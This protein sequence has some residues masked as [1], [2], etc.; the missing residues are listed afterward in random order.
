[1]KKEPAIPSL[2]FGTNISHWLSQASLNRSEMGKWFGEDDVR[3]IADW[4]MDHIRVPVD[5][6]LLENEGAEGHINMEGF[7]WIEK[8]IAW[9]DR[10][11][12]NMI[13][14]MHCLPGHK[15]QHEYLAYN[16]I[17]D[18]DSP[19]RLRARK[20]WRFLA[21]K[22]T[23]PYVIFE[24][25]NEPVAREDR[26]WNELAHELHGEIRSKNP[27]Q[28]IMIG[29]NR[30]NHAQSFETLEPVKDP[31]S[32]YTFHLYE[33]FLF[34]HQN[35]EWVPEMRHLNGDSVPY[36]G[37]F[38]HPILQVV[39]SNP[40]HYE[41]MTKP[42]GYDFLEKIIQPILNFQEKFNASCYCG[43]FG[44]ISG[45][46][47]TDRN[48]WYHDICSLFSNHSIGFSNWDYRSDNFGIVSTDDRIDKDTI[49]TMRRAAGV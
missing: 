2:R 3:R 20:L 43:E 38:T 18:T 45:A 30:W 16:Q 21:E 49:E 34:T 27:S 33:P 6:P 7:G 26:M 42:Y 29:S 11:S 1:M 32:I 28:W 35:A 13:L 5:Y 4:G 47:S 23:E 14:D 48:R 25:L 46:P 39:S 12:L 8:A 19:Y 31:A 40:V 9:C 15:F 37:P 44:C 36:P 17:W 10:Y 22:I 41:F 24:L